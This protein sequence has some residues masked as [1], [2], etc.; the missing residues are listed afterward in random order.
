MNL[1]Y[2]RCR[3]GERFW[4]AA[5]ERVKGAPVYE[6]SHRKEQANQVGFL[7]EVVAEAWFRRSGIEFEDCRDC[8][9]IDYR[10]S[11]NIT[12]DVKTKDRTVLPRSNYD[13]TVPA[14]NHDHQRPNFYLF[15]SLLRDKGWGGSADIKRFVEAQIVGGISLAEFEAKSKFWEAG[16]V[17]PTNGTEFWTSC[18]NVYMH[19]LVPLAEL[20]RVWKG[21]YSELRV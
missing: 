17:D 4:E 19:E 9:D 13:C 3:L 15:I 14:Y 6:R 8:T 7:G 10:L 5:E 1:T 20:V 21:Q 18:W 2:T 12:L 16:Q 11:G